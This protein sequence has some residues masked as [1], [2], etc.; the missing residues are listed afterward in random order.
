MRRTA[1]ARILVLCGALGPAAARAQSDPWFAQDKALHYGV[2]TGLAAGGYA[3]SAFVLERPASRAAAAAGASLVVGLGKELHDEHARGAFSFRDL[4]WDAL[5][6]LTG[7]GVGYLV[8]RFLLTH[9]KA[10]GA[11]AR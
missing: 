3:G 11:K 8:D 9:L 6:A 5:G 7:A 10:S 4:T 1:A 2:S